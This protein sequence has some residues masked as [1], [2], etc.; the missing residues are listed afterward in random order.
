MSQY[1]QRGESRCVATLV[2]V[3]TS[4]LPTPAA[5]EPNLPVEVKDLESGI[6]Q[7]RTG[8][9]APIPPPNTHLGDVWLKRTL[10]ALLKD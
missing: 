7:E 2:L 4:A 10:R 6:K 9:C 5:M 8:S 1:T 3:S